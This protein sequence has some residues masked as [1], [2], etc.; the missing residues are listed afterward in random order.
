MG[1]HL[2][3]NL[4]LKDHILIKFKAAT[5]NIIMMHSIR[6]YLKRE[7]CHKLFLQLVIS[8]LDY[9]NSMI[10]GLP[11]SSI[12]IMQKV[13]NTFTRLILRENAIEST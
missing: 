9:A 5:L 8:H 13:Q 7:T 10:A 2:D 3:S 4:T 11:S 6:K 1:G 12:K